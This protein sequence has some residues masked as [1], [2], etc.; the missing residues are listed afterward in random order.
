MANLLCCPICLRERKD[1]IKAYSVPGSYKTCYHDPEQFVDTKVTGDEFF[2]FYR[3]RFHGY[4]ELDVKDLEDLIELKKTDL[5]AFQAKI[6]E[7]DAIFAQ[8]QQEKEEQK[9]KEEQERNTVRCPKCSCTN[10][11]V[12]PRKWSFWTGFLTN[13]T[14][15]VC[16][17][18]GYKF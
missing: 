8:K 9:R 18:C 7:F 14:D 4:V 3:L 12:I 10:I 5:A 16:V 6:T 13:K 17:K 15:R 2:S 1:K 11:Q